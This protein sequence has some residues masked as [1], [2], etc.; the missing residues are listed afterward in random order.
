MTIPTE[1]WV[2]INTLGLGFI[3]FLQFV[4]NRNSKAAKKQSESNADELSKVHKK[5]NGQSDERVR[6]AVAA[7]RAL[8][9]QV[10]IIDD[11]PDDQEMQA[12]RLRRCGCEVFQARTGIEARRLILSRNGSRRG[13]PFD[14]IF[15]DIRLEA[16]EDALEVLDMLNEVAPN[17]LVAVLT[18]L[19]SV[20][21][22]ICRMGR[23]VITKP[24]N[25]GRSCR[26][27]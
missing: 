20:P 27:S 22:A 6:Q 9:P 16:G 23:Y 26:A 13:Y 15:L 1:A 12:I 17:V 19:D 21:A 14:W 18:G 8:P 11:D 5:V 7:D 3:A 24:L 10:L 2:A 4:G 25:E